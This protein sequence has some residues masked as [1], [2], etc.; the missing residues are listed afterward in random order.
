MFVS[1]KQKPKGT[2][3]RHFSLSFKRE[4]KKCPTS[5]KDPALRGK[6]TDKKD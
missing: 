1:L 2:G 5:E 3:K 6:K 4:V